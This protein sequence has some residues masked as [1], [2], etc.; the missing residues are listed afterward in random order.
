M[1]SVRCRFVF[2]SGETCGK[3]LVF[4]SSE[5]PLHGPLHVGVVRQE[6]GAFGACP[7]STVSK[8]QRL[9]NLGQPP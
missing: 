9:Q 1:I 4:R 3:R 8:V 7:R 5:K 2:K 6:L